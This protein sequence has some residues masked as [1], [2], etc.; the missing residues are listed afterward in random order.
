MTPLTGPTRR[1]EQRA[2]V[3]LT[4]HRWQPLAFI[5]LFPRQLR[6]G[7]SS[8]TWRH[9]GPKWSFSNSTGPSLSDCVILSSIKVKAKVL[10][11]APKMGRLSFLNANHLSQ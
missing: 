3:V 8:K 6:L 5:F 2:E 4:A 7:T 9:L 1:F 10:D 11:L